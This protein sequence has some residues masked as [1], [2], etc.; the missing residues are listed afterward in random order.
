[1]IGGAGFIGSHLV[2]RLLASGC[3][4]DV[5]DDLATGSLAHLAEARATLG[6]L[7]I[8]Q[9]DA[10]RPELAEL[11]ARRR[12]AV[13][14]V[15]AP[16]VD[17]TSPVEV[18]ASWLNVALASMDA[19]RR[20]SRAPGDVKVVAAL[21]GSAF[22]GDLPA[23][24]LPARE[25]GPRRPSSV[26]GVAADAVVDLLALHRDLHAVE[27]T[28]VA[29]ASVYGPRR[30]SPLVGARRA[31]RDLLHVDEAAEALVR[32]GVRAGGLVVNVGSG[33]S[34]P[35]AKY[36]DAVAQEAV[37]GGPART[38]LSPARAR[39]HLGWKP[40]VGVEN[41]LAHLAAP[42]ESGRGESD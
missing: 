6:T 20:A 15:L 28:A 27:F 7:R 21:P 34:T 26:A 4:V 30:S 17:E 11:V 22:Y 39:L 38:A 37:A 29:L 23:R 1:M 33:V 3:V 18:V 8:Q 40:W 32:A 13:L 35:L 41:G 19:A 36:L 10:R 16:F 12:P 31:S 14:Y 9:L 2:D 24:D 42:E 5:V 25:D